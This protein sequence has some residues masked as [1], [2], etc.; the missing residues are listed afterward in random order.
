MIAA[1]NPIA[2]QTVDPA[3]T[4]LNQSIMGVSCDG[5]RRFEPSYEYCL[6]VTAEKG[7]FAT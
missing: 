7:V 2:L 6:S 3:I 1:T 5:I 4:V